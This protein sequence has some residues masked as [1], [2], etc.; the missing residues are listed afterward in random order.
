MLTL[1]CYTPIEAPGAIAEQEVRVF[2]GSYEQ[3]VERRD[4]GLVGKAYS[5]GAEISFTLPGRE[6]SV[7]YTAAELIAHLRLS[8]TRPGYRRSRIVRGFESNPAEQTAVVTTIVTETI[9]SPEGITEVR[10]REE[11]LLAR[12]HGAL[13]IRRLIGQIE[14]P[15]AANS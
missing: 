15:R 12:R 14:P 2:L 13:A 4:W 8:I 3:A 10:S 9:W 6:E 1:G 5:P 11:L 7:T